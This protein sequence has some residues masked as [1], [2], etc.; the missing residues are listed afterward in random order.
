MQSS[1][2]KDPVLVIHQPLFHFSIPNADR[3]DSGTP[4]MCKGT[5]TVHVTLKTK[6]LCKAAC[7]ALHWNGPVCVHY[8]IVL[9]LHVHIRVC[10]GAIQAQLDAQLKLL[11]ARP[12]SLI[13]VIDP[14]PAWKPRVGTG[15][16]ST[17]IFKDL[18]SRYIVLWKLHACT[19][20]W[21]KY[22]YVSVL[23]YY[24]SHPVKMISFFAQCVMCLVEGLSR[25]SFVSHSYI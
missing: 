13:I 8:V 10:S 17:M 5:C 15:T 19:C 7:T 20:I 6:H 22:M 14:N 3:V 4:S 18:Y 1:E 2:K 21:V 12:D 24:A 16:D 25:K 11:T 9:V 23:V